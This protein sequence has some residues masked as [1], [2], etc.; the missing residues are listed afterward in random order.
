MEYFRGDI[1]FV[2]KS[3]YIGEECGGGR[4]AVIV[5]NNTGNHF[6]NCVEI[7]YLSSSAKKEMPTHVKVVCRCLSTALC[8]QIY[9]VS[10]ERITQY[11]RSCT[12]EEMQKIDEALMISLGLDKKALT[13][14]EQT[15]T[16]TALKAQ[17]K[18]LEAQLT[19]KRMEID[20]MLKMADVEEKRAKAEAEIKTNEEII[21]LT[22][23][24]NVFKKLYEDLLEKVTG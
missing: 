4:P 18:Q 19:E 22:A 10:K 21:K 9:T 12:D 16:E 23:E 17:I 11:V 20:D 24:K 14:G 5:S 13:S 1:V 7:V 2:E 3:K 6:S 15:A 8:E